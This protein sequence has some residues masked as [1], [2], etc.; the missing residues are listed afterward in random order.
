MTDT[1][2][3][4]IATCGVDFGW[5]SVGKLSA[6]MR[7]C[8]QQ[9]PGIRFVMLGTRLGRAVLADEQIEAWYAHW[10]RN[11][12]ELRRL[13]QR[14]EVSAALVVLD[15]DAADTLEAAACP[16][17]FVDSLPYLWTDADPLPFDVTAYCAQT[18]PELPQPSWEALRRI[19]RLHWVEGIYA[20]VA[21]R[22]RGIGSAIVNVGGLHS[23]VNRAG[24]PQYLRLVVPAALRA[25]QR[26]GFRAVHL[27][28][29]VDTR[30][31]GTELDSRELDVGVAARSHDN[32]LD[33]L[34]ETALLVTS[35]GLTTLF[36]AS[37]HETPTVTLPPQNLSQVFNGDRF[38]LAVDSRCRV[39]W[40]PGVLDRSEVERS[41][42]AG[43]E[44]GIAVIDRAL[45]RLRPD[46]LHPQLT[47]QIHDAVC[48]AATVARWDGLTSSA[49]CRGADQVAR[50]LL[51]ASDRNAPAL[52][53][54]G[55][56]GEPPEKNEQKHPDVKARSAPRPTFTTRM[57]PD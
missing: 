39:E 27:C 5:G 31:L 3:T 25:L 49:G 52:S 2:A 43:E 35:P 48:A 44:A 45:N 40:P 32:F 34:A 8:R 56:T 6:I 20:K 42:L 41:R 11:P 16:T 38:A 17:V 21:A 13:L 51:E 12:T 9:R 55:L 24:N 22:T 26:A 15:P 46:A 57:V 28:G 30:D 1:A 29:N 7:S 37:A 10:P 53:A 50:L 47:D 18:C 23:P 14:H 36:E 54:E 33:L 19:A 4:S